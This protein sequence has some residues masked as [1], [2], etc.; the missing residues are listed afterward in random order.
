[1]VAAIKEAC[2]EAF[3]GAK[4]LVHELHFEAIM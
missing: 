2:A 4:V 3:T 1:M